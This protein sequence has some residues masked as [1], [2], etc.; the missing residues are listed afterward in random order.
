[1]KKTPSMDL[2]HQD[3]MKPEY[4]FDYQKAKANRF[5]GQTDEKRTVVVLDPELSTVF[6]TSDAVTKV[7]RALVKTMPTPGAATKGRE[8][9]I[10]S[11]HSR[12]D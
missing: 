2:S 4:S 6:S 9:V 8:T 11:Q 7:L 3:D 5:A 1:M 12:S 10:K